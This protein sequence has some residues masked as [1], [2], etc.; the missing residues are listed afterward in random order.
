M[1]SQAFRTFRR[2]FEVFGRNG[3]KWLIRPCRALP[4]RPLFMILSGRSEE[5]LDVLGRIEYGV[6]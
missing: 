1:F 2:T 4:R 6:F 3:F 5:V